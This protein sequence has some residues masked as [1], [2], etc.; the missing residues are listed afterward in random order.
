MSGELGS[1]PSFA[2]FKLDLSGLSQMLGGKLTSGE[3]LVKY[4]EQKVLGINTDSR[5]IAPGEVF[6]ALKGERFDGHEY[7]AK[8][9][10]EGAIACVVDHR[11]SSLSSE[12]LTIEVPDT[13]AALGALALAIRNQ[14]D[15]VVVAVTGSVGKTTI[16]TMLYSILNLSG[17]KVSS[18]QGNFNNHVGLPL[19]LIRLE[20]DV[21]HAVVEL[22]ANHMGEIAALTAICRPDVGVVSMAGEAHLEF[23]G[24]INQVAKAKGELYQGLNPGAVA[25]VNASD[26]LMVQEAQAFKGNKLLFGPK[27]SGAHVTYYERTDLGLMGQ[28]FKLS[29]PGQKN[30]LCLELKLGGVHNA[31]NAAAAAAA[32]LASGVEW[33]DIAQGLQTVVPVAGR[34]KPLETKDGRFIIDD[35]YN[36][37]PRSVEMALSY[38][39]SLSNVKGAILGDMLELG[40]LSADFHRQ[41]GFWA[42]KA[43]LDFLA[44]VGDLMTQAQKG[45]VEAGLPADTI[46][47]FHDPHQAAAWVAQRYPKGS[48]TLVKGSHS[49]RLDKAVAFLVS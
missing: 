19:T 39:G 33:A 12:S 2:A 41:V 28:R 32:A 6:V 40:P 5:S 27:G 15:P 31:L 10:S 1:G 35:S 7:V 47:T 18:T 3:G 42:A 30:P 48:V 24:S 13:L 25:V 49:L 23:F 14:V 11:D 16:K 46:A 21:S 22:G 20:P 9:L 44:L 34:L 43:K 17:R 4:S 37:N 8:A 45:A 26:P 38:L 36:A 29:G